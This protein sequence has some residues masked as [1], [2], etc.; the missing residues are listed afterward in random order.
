[1][2]WLWRI[3]QSRYGHQLLPSSASRSTAVRALRRMLTPLTA[4]P[5][6]DVERGQGESLLPGF[7]ACRLPRWTGR[8]KKRNECPTRKW[9]KEKGR[10]HEPS[11]LKR[12]KAR[13]RACLR[14]RQRTYHVVGRAVVPWCSETS[15]IPREVLINWEVCPGL[16]SGW[17]RGSIY[18]VLLVLGSALL[19]QNHYPRFTGAPSGHFRTLPRRPP[20]VDSGLGDHDVPYG[21][22]P[23]RTAQATLVQVLSEMLRPCPD[24]TA[25]TEHVRRAGL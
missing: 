16:R 22:R 17:L 15:R 4:R 8:T 11:G 6:A 10:T 20:S 13:I 7:H 24:R 21:M 23:L 9:A 14:S 19:F 3:T 5:S 2:C 25:Q 1:M 18:W 12:K